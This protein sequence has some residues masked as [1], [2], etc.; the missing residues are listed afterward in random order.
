MEGLSNIIRIDYAD[1]E[2]NE[3]IVHLDDGEGNYTTH[4]TQNENLFLGF[5]KEYVVPHFPIHHD[6]RKKIP[7]DKYLKSLKTLFTTLF[8]IAPEIFS[9]LTY[10]FNSEEI[11]KPGFFKLY[12]IR[13][14]QFLY[15]LNLDLLY[16]AQYAEIIERGDNDVTPEYRT[17]VV[18]LHGYFLP[19]EEVVM[20]GDKVSGFKVKQSISETWIGEQGRGYLVKGIWIDDKLTK[21]FTR[22]FLPPKKRIYPYYPFLCMYK[23]FCGHLVGLSS[24]KRE[25]WLPYYNKASRFLTPYIRRIEKAL[26]DSPFS[27]DLALFKKIKKEVPPE[28]LDMCGNIKVEVYLNHNDLKEYKIEH[29]F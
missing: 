25:Q 12:K 24:R 5:E 9:G 4:F 19:V 6:V 15:L 21:F 16:N 8:S 14:K 2:I 1:K 27:D 7:G 3:V 23:T 29:A 28:L 18:F 26:K 11:L 20:N 13:K 22:L 10:Y 17:K